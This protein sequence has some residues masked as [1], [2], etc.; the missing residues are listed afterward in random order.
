M[1]ISPLLSILPLSI[2]SKMKPVR[3]RD[4]LMIEF[5]YRLNQSET[6]FRQGCSILVF[7]KPAMTVSFHRVF[8][9]S[10][11]ISYL[12]FNCE[13][14]PHWISETWLSAS[15]VLL[16]DQKRHSGERC[17]FWIL[18]INHYWPEEIQGIEYCRFPGSIGTENQ[19]CLQDSFPG[20]LC[21]IVIFQMP[22]IVISKKWQ[23]LPL[24]YREKIFY[25]KIYYHGLYL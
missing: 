4:G 17:I 6:S 24:S 13:N 19:A 11:T 15:V 2:F 7:R 8:F 18:G 9:A 3:S 16:Y 1:G 21:Y 14:V 5:K 10:T 22:N 25:R 23:C 12:S 20:N